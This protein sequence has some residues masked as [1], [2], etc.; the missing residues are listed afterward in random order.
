MLISL[1]ETIDLCLKAFDLRCGRLVSI[2][3][4]YLL[5]PLSLGVGVFNDLLQPFDFCLS[6]D[7]LLFFFRQQSGCFLGGCLSRSL[8]L[9]IFFLFENPDALSFTGRSLQLNSKLIKLLLSR[10]AGGLF[11]RNA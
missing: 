9:D 6:F 2:I 7:T 3:D 4:G 10:C 5:Q 8:L 1:T 11:F